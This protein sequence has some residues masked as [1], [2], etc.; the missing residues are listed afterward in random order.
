MSQE[1]DAVETTEAESYTRV[2]LMDW[3]ATAEVF[4]AFDAEVTVE[5]DRIEVTS[6][7]ARFV[8]ARD[9]TVHGSMPLHDLE[10]GGVEQ[11]GLDPQRGV[12]CVEQGRDRYEFRLP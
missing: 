6:G 7:D 9:G 1:T 5:D 8:V 12:I 4:R 10:R 3:A 11:L 2:R